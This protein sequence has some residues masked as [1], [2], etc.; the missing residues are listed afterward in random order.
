MSRSVSQ[1]H[2]FLHVNGVKPSPEMRAWLSDTASLT[3]KLTAVSSQFRIRRLRQEHS[4]CLA[5]EF[6]EAGLARRCRVQEREVL[7]Q[8]DGCPMVFAHTILPLSATASDWPFFGRLGERSLGTTLF[9]DPRVTR[10]ALQFAHLKAQHPLVRRASA[11]VGGIRQP[12]YAR[13][14]TY[15]RNNGV[16]LVTEVFLPAMH[17]MMDARRTGMKETN[18]QSI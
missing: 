18:K 11:A 16:L 5:D 8:C 13:R 6:E 4:L 12:L 17:E 10:G 14:C 2:W 3:M 15:R 7:L 9:G 1:A